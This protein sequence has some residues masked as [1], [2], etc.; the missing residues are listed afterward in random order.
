M[1]ATEELQVLVVEDRGS[2]F[3]SICEHISRASGANGFRV[4]HVSSAAEATE[5][6]GRH[7]HLLIVDTR[8][9]STEEG[10]PKCK[11]LLQY[12]CLVVLLLHRHRAEA[13]I[14]PSVRNPS[15]FV[16]RA[17]ANGSTIEMVTR[18][19][20]QLMQAGRCGEKQAAA[21]AL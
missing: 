18:Y 16:I 7:Y 12:P 8:T 1:K 14:Q 9:A 3:G 15:Q 21:M 13:I 6:C 20:L 11:A 10:W 2:D 5:L 4:D 17:I 19:A